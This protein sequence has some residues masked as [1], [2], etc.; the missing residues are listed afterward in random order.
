MNANW[1]AG[2]LLKW[3]GPAT[4]T[5]LQRHFTNL[6]NRVIG[7][8]YTA[9]AHIVAGLEQ[10]NAKSRNRVFKVDEMEEP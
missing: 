4:V 7:G 9:S 8:R 2:F 10:E 1:Q 6:A 3:V 5:R